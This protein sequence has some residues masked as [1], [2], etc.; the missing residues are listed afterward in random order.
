MLLFFV[1]AAPAEPPVG[2]RESIYRDPIMSDRHVIEILLHPDYGQ[3]PARRILD[4]IFALAPTGRILHHHI[5]EMEVVEDH[6]RIKY[7]INQAPA[8]PDRYRCQI[9]PP[10]VPQFPKLD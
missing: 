6:N 1:R 2:K 4:C 3:I 8:A 5:E 10:M 9:I 7:S